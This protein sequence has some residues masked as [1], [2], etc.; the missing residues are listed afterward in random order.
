MVNVYRN[1][2]DYWDPPVYSF[3]FRKI[4]YFLKA[5]VRMFS[6]FFCLSVKHCAG[7]SLPPGFQILHSLQYALSQSLP[8]SLQA[9]CK[10][11]G[12]LSSS[13]LL[14]PQWVILFFHCEHYCCHQ[15]ICGALLNHSFY[16]SPT[17]DLSKVVI[18]VCQIFSLKPSLF[19][20][21]PYILIFPHALFVAY[22]L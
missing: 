20:L 5:K 7:G 12:W 18:Q 19:L 10:L 21:T 22:L 6:G 13:S 11:P 15:C 16:R 4:N 14:D 9:V 8:F 1:V 17:T 2:L 3:L